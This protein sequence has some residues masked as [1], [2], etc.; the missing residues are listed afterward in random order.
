MAKHYYLIRTPRH[1]TLPLTA[2]NCSGVK[3]NNKRLAIS[4]AKKLAGDWK[5][6][7]PVRNRRMSVYTVHRGE[8]PSLLA[9]YHADRRTGKIVSEVL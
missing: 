5:D 9:Q 6:V 4:F 7:T 2:R 3:R 8:R 1:R